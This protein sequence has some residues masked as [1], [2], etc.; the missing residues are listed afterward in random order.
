M[1][2]RA[3][4]TIIIPTKKIGSFMMLPQGKLPAIPAVYFF[5]I[6]FVCLNNRSSLAGLQV[7]AAAGTV[8]L[9]FEQNLSHHFPLTNSSVVLQA[10]M[11][12]IT[13]V[14]SVLLERL[15]AATLADADLLF[16]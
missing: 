8:F 9:L 14:W 16:I 10:A 6:F 1:M 13:I 7:L 2:A 5:F 3:N 12:V 15:A 4:T 11:G